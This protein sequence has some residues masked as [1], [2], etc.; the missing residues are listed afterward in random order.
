[1]SAAPGEAGLLWLWAVVAD[2]GAT[3]ASSAP[4]GE[5]T[6]A[7]GRCQP[8]RARVAPESSSSR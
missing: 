5:P 7:P 8:M 6:G 4:A 3:A 1:M 2:I